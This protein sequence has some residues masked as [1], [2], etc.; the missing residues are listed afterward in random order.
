M[1][2]FNI[3]DL[4]IK[5][6]FGFKL[7]LKRKKAKKAAMLRIRSSLKYKLDL[8]GLSKLSALSVPDK[9][10]GDDQATEAKTLKFLKKQAKKAG[11][12]QYDSR[13]S[14][15]VSSSSD[16]QVDSEDPEE[17]EDIDAQS[18]P[19]NTNMLLIPDSNLVNTKLKKHKKSKKKVQ[20]V[21]LLIGEPEVENLQKVNQIELDG[22][23]YE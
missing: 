4:I 15:H 22:P 2:I 13:H 16:E 11:E 7:Y 9:E 21:R 3:A 10:V 19:I 23:S 14:V 12:A 5:V 18:A 6:I 8:G 20:D 17:L 1:I